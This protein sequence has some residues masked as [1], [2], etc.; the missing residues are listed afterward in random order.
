[1][2]HKV[3]RWSRFRCLPFEQKRILVRAALALPVHRFGLR[4]AGLRRWQSFLAKLAPTVASSPAEPLD[5]AI[6][7]AQAVCRASRYGLIRATCLEQSTTLW[8]LLRR[9]G[10]PAELRIGARKELG[11]FEAHAWVELAG[12]VLAPDALY[13]RFVPFEPINSEM[14][15]H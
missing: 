1:V 8:W 15:I 7:H 4:L 12:T 11:R 14:R 9:S 10:L 5:R 3:T 2:D 6:P 13:Q